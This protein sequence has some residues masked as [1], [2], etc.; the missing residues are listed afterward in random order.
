MMKPFYLCLLFSILLMGCS[1]QSKNFTK[2]GQLKLRGGVYGSEQWSQSLAFERYSWFHELTLLFDVLIVKGD[3]LGP[4]DSWLSA[5]E[6]SQS[7][8]CEEFNIVLVYGSDSDKISEHTFFEQTRLYG[9]DRQ[10]IADFGSHLKLHPDFERL[11]LQLYKPYGL[12]KKNLAFDSASTPT[13]L[14]LNFP[15]FKEV[16]ID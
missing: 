7:R 9:Y 15:G 4:F 16:T 13:T 1:S 6:L 8:N 10:H 2:D 3:Q 5:S 11:S 12:C 14:R